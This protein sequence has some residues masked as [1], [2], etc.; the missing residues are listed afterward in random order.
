M[1][2]YKKGES[3]FIDYYSNG[4]RKRESVGPS[5]KF[6]EQVLAKRKTQIKEGQYF[7]IK[8]DKTI[9][10]EEIVADFLEYS[11]NNKR[12]YSRDVCSIKQ[13]LAFLGGKRL[14]E[15]TPILMEQYKGKRLNQGEVSPATVNR[16]VACLKA[17]F[18]W[19]IKSKKATENPVKQVKLFKENNTRTR[20]LEEDEARRLL[21]A[22]IYWF[23]PIVI[24]ALTT[25][26]RKGEI[27]SLKWDDINWKQNIIFLK[28]TKNSRNREIPICSLLSKVLL[29]CH[30]RTDGIFVFC[31]DQKRHL[32]DNRYFYTLFNRALKFAGIQDFRFHDLR[33]TA[34]S[35]LVMGGVDLATVKEILGHQTINMTLRYAHLSP[36]HKRSAMQLL[37]EKV[38]TFWTPDKNLNQGIEIESVKYPLL[39][40]NFSDNCRRSSVAEQWF[41]KP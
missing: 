30:E 24:T 7:E 20:Y 10:I 3:W 33:H 39:L 40:G 15:I 13:L 21:D 32:N 11:K 22:C 17:I 1:G 38:D 28:N 5:K 12:S 37:G 25:G 4:S 35:Y 23:R 18:N 36:V 34:A 27:L 14:T 9:M 16:E 26:M 29:E 6:A 8:K 19:S 2:L 41:R 31:N